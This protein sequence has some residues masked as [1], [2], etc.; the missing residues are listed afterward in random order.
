MDISLP[1]KVVVRRDGIN[2]AAPPQA[3]GH[4]AETAAPPFVPRSR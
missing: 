1:V 3:L 4:P 2:R